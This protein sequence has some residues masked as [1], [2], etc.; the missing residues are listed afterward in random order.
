LVD[1][2]RDFTG[3]VAV[4]GV[5]NA[6][7]Y[8]TGNYR[9]DETAG[10]LQLMNQL[11]SGDTN[12][13]FMPDKNG[14]DGE[15]DNFVNIWATGGV[16]AE[17]L[18]IGYES[19]LSPQR[20]VI[21]TF[22][23]SGGVHH[24]IYFVHSGSDVMTVDS[25]GL[26]LLDG[27]GITLNSGDITSTSGNVTLDS[28]DVNLNTGNITL[29]SGNIAL[30][31]GDITF[32][33]AFVPKMVSENTTIYLRTTGDDSNGGYSS[34]DAFL[35]PARA[36]TELHKWTAED[37]FL[38]VD[39][40][41]GTFNVAATIN[42]SHVYGANIVWIGKSNNHTTLTINNID[43][44]PLALSAGLEYIDFDINFAAG[45]GAAVGLFILVKTTSGGS[46]PNLV[47]GCHEIIAWSANVATVRCV[48]VAG[49]TT[50]PSGT[51]T[52]DTLTLVKTVFNFNNSTHG[53][54]GDNSRHC[55]V[56]DKMVLKGTLGYLGIWMILGST[57][58][59]GS[60]FGT[61]KWEVNLASQSKS[62]IY[63]S[64]STH[65]YGHTYLA[66]LDGGGFMSLNSAI[67]S[68]CWDTALRA[69]DNGMVNFQEGQIFC[70]GTFRPVQA[71]R[72]GFINAVSSV[73]EGCLTSGSTAFYATSGGGI[74]ASSATDDAA[75]SNA[76]EAAPGGNG[77]YIAY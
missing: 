75:T 50:L 61:S 12:F 26:T 58:V 41:E 32:D 34:G 20:Y 7:A 49:S 44:A 47:K 10:R 31:D 51:I 42:P 27:H 62:N 77:A 63:A 33:G 21:E 30:T 55:G 74:D 28:G 4:Q 60:N 39:V 54:F 37:Y 67:L 66:T 35:T 25:N 2:T 18:K 38:T 24:P 23:I 11:D 68:G 71:L 19:D 3:N 6:E 1:G 16:S 48:R 64:G 76:T 69:F 5:V 36:V 46:N 13:D 29:N 43:G 56:W 57:I 9:I 14:G 15:D 73:V 22:G 45:S 52:G 70:G 53:L 17:Y 8:D 40:G 59:L 72:G 65:S